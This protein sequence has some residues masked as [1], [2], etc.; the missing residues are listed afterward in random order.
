M[1]LDL[2]HALRAPQIQEAPGWPFLIASEATGAEAG[3]VWRSLP[4]G[5]VSR[6]TFSSGVISAMR[7]S[8]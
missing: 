1:A 7:R 4:L 3:P 6:P 8:K 5:M 2:A